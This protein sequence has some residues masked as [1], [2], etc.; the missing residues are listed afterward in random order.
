MVGKLAPDFRANDLTGR[1]IYLNAELKRPVVLSF[2]ATWCAPCRD[3]IPYLIDLH[4]RFEGRATILCIV[5]DPENTDKVRSIASSLS[6]TY[7]I[8]MDEGQKIMESYG[9]G[10]LPSTFL[11]GPDGRIRSHFKGFGEAE[12]KAL[13]AS[14]ERLTNS[15]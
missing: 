11:I 14:I 4:R 10:T 7:P 12:A 15:K 5:V 8:L 6:I 1:T 2:F 13:A 9:A 3:E